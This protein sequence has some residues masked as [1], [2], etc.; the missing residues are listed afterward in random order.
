MTTIDSKLLHTITGGATKR[1]QITDRLDTEATH[2]GVGSP[3]SLRVSCGPNKSGTQLCNGT[4]K[5][6]LG[7]GGGTENDA[8]NA[9][10]EKGQLK[11]LQT[12]TTGG[13]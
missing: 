10:F 13:D 12:R 6:W 7:P 2:R 4:F 1:Q 5:T 11:H 9:V 8:F 3:S